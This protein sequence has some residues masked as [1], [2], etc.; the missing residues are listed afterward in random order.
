MSLWTENCR[1]TNI[2]ILNLIQTKLKQLTKAT[3]TIINDCL[4]EWNSEIAA[5][6]LK[7]FT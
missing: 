2:Q 1:Q 7:H 6:Y 4:W 3:Y 5:T